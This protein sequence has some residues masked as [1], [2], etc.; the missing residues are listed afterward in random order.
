MA[1]RKS[2]ADNARALVLDTN[3]PAE[4]IAWLCSN[5]AV[6]VFAD[7]VSA[8]KAEKLRPVLD[9]IHTLKPNRLEAELL[10]GVEIRDRASLHAAADALLEK[11][12]RRVFIT[13]GGDGVLAAEE[14]N[15][16]LLGPPKGTV[17]N[18]TGCGDAFSAGLVWAYRN[19]LDL[20]D[21]AIAGQT[22]AAIAMESPE[23][24][25][26]ALSEELLTARMKEFDT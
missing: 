3:L 1:E 26:S 5:T 7:P 23:T 11:G 6:P 25:N 16:W 13:T 18:T 8:V 17:V 4:T 9:R 20:R 19:G 10:S 22:A 24:I 12:V 14:G 21:S 15:R 2:L